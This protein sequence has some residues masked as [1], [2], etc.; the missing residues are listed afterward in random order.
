[1]TKMTSRCLE[2]GQDTLK[3]TPEKHHFNLAE[4][5]QVIKRKH[6]TKYSG[7]DLNPRGIVRNKHR[8][9]G[10]GQRTKFIG[11]KERVRVV[12]GQWKNHEGQQWLWVG[13]SRRTRC[14]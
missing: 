5:E 9:K 7:S 12:H 8:K 1:M 11:C 10:Q 14:P 6:I 2:V 4:L 3:Y 13:L